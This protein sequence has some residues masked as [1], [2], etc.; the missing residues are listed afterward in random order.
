[1]QE[2]TARSQ[3]KLRQPPRLPLEGV[4]TAMPAWGM[5]LGR[6]SDLQAKPYQLQLPNPWPDQCLCLEPSFL[7][8]AAGQFR[9]FTGFPFQPS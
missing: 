9:F 6:S 1:M 2:E 3:G 8:T 5:L 7:L 4:C